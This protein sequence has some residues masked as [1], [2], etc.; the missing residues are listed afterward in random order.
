MQDSSVTA[1]RRWL[2][3]LLLVGLT[4]TTT[5]LVLLRHYEDAWMLPPFA[6][7]AVAAG[8]TIARLVRPSPLTVQWLRLSMLPL[9]VAGIAGAWL[10]Y[11]G[12]LAFQADM[13]PTLSRWALFWKVLH[14]Q[15]P[16]MLAPGMLAQF[17]LLG[18]LSSYRDP[19][20]TTT[21]ASSNDS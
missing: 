13:D 20:T 21:E 1:L 17:A 6:A 5:E 9:L 18:L 14:M 10:H 2:L 3:L 7:I 19:L 8:G 15:A 12:G 11:L 16:P 4:G